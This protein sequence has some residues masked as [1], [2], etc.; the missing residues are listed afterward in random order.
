MQF[1]SFVP[2]LNEGMYAQLVPFLVLFMQPISNGADHI[3]IQLELPSMDG[4]FQGSEEV[5]IWKCL[6]RA[7]GWMQ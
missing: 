4:T 1:Y 6:V 5:K 3:I 7:A 2:M